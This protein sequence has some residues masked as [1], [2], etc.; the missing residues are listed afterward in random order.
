MTQLA[1]DI[2]Y[3]L[4]ILYKEHIDHEKHGKEKFGL[5]SFILWWEHFGS[6]YRANKTFNFLLSKKLIVKGQRGFDINTEGINYLLNKEYRKLKWYYWENIT[7]TADKI[8]KPISLIISLTTIVLAI[9]SCSYATKE[10]LDLIN[11]KTDSLSVRL[12]SIIEQTKK[13]DSSKTKIATE[14][15]TSNLSTGKTINIINHDDHRDTA[16]RHAS[17]TD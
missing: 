9:K 4:D 2:K 15:K 17:K 10:D 8:N 1:E 5:N 13:E 14:N 3:V 11:K 6:E 16:N 7:N 12:T